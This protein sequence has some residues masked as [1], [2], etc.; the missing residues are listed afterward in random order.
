MYY[1]TEAL[2]SS[3]TLRESV[4]LITD[5]RFS[6]ATRGPAIGHVSPEMVCGGPIGVIQDEDLIEINF[7][8]N[9]INCVG[10]RGQR[11]NPEG[12]VQVLE[13]RLQQFTPP[14]PEIK[15]GLLGVYQRLALSSACG[16]GF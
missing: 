14:Q 12:I 4:A 6:G 10:A 2:A 11:Q 9:A 16:G 3:A 7:S 15:R 1:I 8:Q 5:G 13:A